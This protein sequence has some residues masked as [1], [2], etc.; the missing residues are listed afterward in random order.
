MIQIPIA[1]QMYTLRNES[2]QD[3]VGTL[4]KVAKLGFQ[5]VEL[6]GYHGLTSAELKKV[7]D[8]LGLRIASS[9]IPLEDLEDNLVR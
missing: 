5:G 8:S 7:I 3:F 9:H 2:E 6:A 4:E 1:L